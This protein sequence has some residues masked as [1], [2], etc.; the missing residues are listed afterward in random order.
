MKT[1]K[2]DKA[3]KQYKIFNKDEDGRLYCQPDTERFYYEVG[4]EYKSNKVDI[5][6]AG[7][8]SCKRLTD[9]LS[10]YPLS[11]SVV[12][13]EVEIWGKQEEKDNKI[14]S[15]Y[16]RITKIL[17]WREAKKILLEENKSLIINSKNIIKSDI[18]NDSYNVEKGDMI[19][20]SFNIDNS[21]RVIK[22]ENV[23]NSNEILKSRLVNYSSFIIRSRVVEG[24]ERVRY[25]HLIDNS[26]N[27][28]NSKNIMNCNNILNSICIYNSDIV[29][30]S[31]VICN[32]YFIR[33]CSAL[34][35]CLFCYDIKAKENYLF[36]K[37]VSEDRIKEIV[38][39]LC[40]YLE[41][42]RSD[43]PVEFN[44]FQKIKKRYK[45]DLPLEA[46]NS[47]DISFNLN[48][49]FLEYIK[50]LPEFDNEVWQKIIEK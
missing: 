22:S 12:Y 9:C 21:S 20:Y 36:N 48:K 16:L 5:C 39:K 43:V 13:A 24:A 11:E 45:E 7:F 40:K 25:S 2:K 38:N 29:I 14:A 1:I 41:L 19:D 37:E 28:D 44:N 26:N 33:E 4:K 8:H 31:Q 46:V 18:I 17:N 3:I 15:K 34:S 47:T 27:I 50:S 10:Y 42:Y 23:S 49:D 32:S 30:N 35:N 6:G